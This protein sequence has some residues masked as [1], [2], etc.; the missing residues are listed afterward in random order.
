MASQSV[1]IDYVSTHPALDISINAAGYIAEDIRNQYMD[2][3]RVTRELI[4][5]FDSELL[6][7]VL[8]KTRETQ[9]SCISLN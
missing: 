6:R 9:L 3:V 2:D 4:E 1:V 8:Q 5:R 7:P